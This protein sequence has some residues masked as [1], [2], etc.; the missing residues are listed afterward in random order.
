[1][2]AEVIGKITNIEIIAQGHGIRELAR[3]KKEHGGRR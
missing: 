1:M 2:Y 3:L